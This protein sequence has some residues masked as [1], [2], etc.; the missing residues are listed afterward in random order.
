M[1]AISVVARARRAGVPIL[2]WKRIYRG[3]EADAPHAAARPSDGSLLRARND[4]GTVRVQR[5]ATPGPSSD[6]SVWTSL[7]AVAV[8]GSGIAM[9]A[10]NAEALLLYTRGTSLYYRQS[11]DS[12]ATWGAE[13]LIVNEGAAIAWI[14]VDYRQSTGDCCAFYTVGATVKRLRRTA[15][16]WAGA[17][18]AWTNTV[19]SITG[20]A[21]ANDGF[22]YALLLTG[23]EQTTTHRRTWALT[24]GDGGSPVNIWS[25]LVRVADAD[26]ASTTTFAGPSLA[27]M[28]GT[29]LHGALVAKETGNVAYTRVLE[30]HPPAGAAPT[31]A[32]SEPAPAEASSAFGLSFARSPSVTDSAFAATASSVWSCALDASFDLTTRM[33][34]ARVEFG[35]ESGAA[36]LEFD[37]ADAVV[38][39]AAAVAPGHDITV[40]AGYASGA[41]GAPEFGSL[42]TLAID[43]ISIS[44]RDGQRFALIEAS[45]PWQQAA[46]WSSPQAWQVAAGA[47]TRVDILTRLTARA[48]FLT[49]TPAPLA[50]SSDLSVTTPSFALAQGDDAATAIAK[51]LAPVHDG[52]RTDTD[53]RFGIAN[54]EDRRWAAKVWALG[55]LAWW[56]LHEAAGAGIAQDSG[57]AIVNGAFQG[58]TLLAQP[59]PLTAQLTQATSFDGVDDQVRVTTP[60]ALNLT[61]ALSVALLVRMAVGTVN[62]G[63]FEKTI[64]NAVNTH[65]LLLYESNFAKFRVFKGGVGYTASGS[66]PGMADG[67]WHLLVGTYDGST[68]RVYVDGALQATTAAVAAPIASGAG[69][70]FI[71]ALASVYRL[72]GGLSEVAVFDRALSG[73]EVSALQSARSPAAFALGGAGEH[74]IARIEPRAGTPGA[75]W[76]RLQGPDRYADAFDANSLAVVGPRREWSRQLDA[77]TNA[78]ALSYGAGALRRATMDEAD[79]GRAIV[80][81]HAGIELFDLIQLSGVGALSPAIYRV[82]GLA[83]D[84]SRRPGEARYDATITL[85]EA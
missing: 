82:N 25:A 77:T 40:R 72:N 65:Y 74:P 49:Y 62:A 6:F 83:L 18:T 84:Y 14:A 48:G 85:G 46:R 51:L 54:R 61:G 56:R 35:P 70:V 66:Q 47:M 12:G 68:A 43:A 37:D 31:L 52:L 27:T 30:T 13:T 21:A 44:I 41:A 28:P 50:P 80:P 59:G 45:G 63:F 2:Q 29:T 24:L 79:Q 16:A 36:R 1:P 4:A 57:T 20:I 76:L 23:T 38:S 75:N 42:W 5:I 78:K 9:A 7:G 60:T 67:A 32:W 34:A 73:T 64:A 17:G 3:N 10:R 15:G 39:G 81:W 26:A 19:A 53:A 69:D 8:S 55:P 22:D 71:G 33:V 11:N 58:G